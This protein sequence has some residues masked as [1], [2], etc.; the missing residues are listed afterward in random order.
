M[1][2]IPGMNDIFDLVFIDADKANYCSY[3][4]LVFDKVRA[5]GWILADNVLY[6]GEVILPVEEQSK[7]ARAMHA[8]NEKIKAD[9][10]VEQVLLPIRDGI[11]IT[12]KY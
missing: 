4:D 5:G 2:I 7:N 9:G 6:N 3:Y 1:D 8:Y 12:R 11:L 10:R